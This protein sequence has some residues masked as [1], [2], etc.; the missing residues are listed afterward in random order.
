MAEPG[1]EVDV[2]GL[3]ETQ[4]KMEQIV[5]DLHGEPMLDALREGTL[6]V[7][8]SAKINAPVD[9]GRL[10]ASITPEVSVE[11]TTVQGVV[12][13]N[14]VYAPYMEFGTG[15]HA[16]HSPYFPPPA[17]LEIWARRHGTTGFAVAFAIFKAGGLKAR[18]FL[19][20]ALEDNTQR[21]IELIERAV[22]GITDK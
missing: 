2:K 20:N 9:V 13:S 22:G 19:Q 1:I 3:K 18:K 10:R 15:V 16:G 11:G 8:R 6:L 12:G 4:A 5:R 21:I 14:V 17:A 7:Q